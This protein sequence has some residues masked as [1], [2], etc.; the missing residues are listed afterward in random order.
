MAKKLS[1][2]NQ[3]MRKA[4][5]GKLKGKT[6]AQRKAIFKAAAKG[7]K[8][9]KTKTRSNPKPKS[10][11]IVKRSR[12]NPTTKRG[13]K[14]GRGFLSTQSLMKYVRIGAL[15]APA[16]STLMDANLSTQRKFKEVIRK[17]TGWE[18]DNARWNYQN[19]LEGWLPYLGAVLVTYGIPKVASMIRRL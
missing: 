15:G 12:S 18:S 19:L 3:Y 8:G 7:W 1:A 4:L 13:G 14:M 16:I 9:Q 2:Y 11:S 10:R 17:Y 6:K 5:K